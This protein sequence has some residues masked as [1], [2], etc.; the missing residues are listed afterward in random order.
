MYLKTE[1]TNN[2]PPKSSARKYGGSI[3]QEV[4]FQSD[5]IMPCEVSGYPVPKYRYSYFN[6]RILPSL[7]PTNNVAPKSS[8]EKFGIIFLQGASQ[9]DLLM[10]CEVSEY[11]VPKFR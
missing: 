3:I 6:I 8:A 4:N 7:E 1:P 10:T 5:I 9:K 11:P 2:V